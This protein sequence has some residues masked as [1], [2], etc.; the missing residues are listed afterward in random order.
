MISPSLQITANRFLSLAFRL[1]LLFALINHAVAAEPDCG[2]KLVDGTT[3][4]A[5]TSYIY[6]SQPLHPFYQ[7]EN[8]DGYCG[9]VSMMQAGLNN[10]QWMSQ[11]NARLICGTS[12]SQSGPNGACAAHHGN[13]NYNAQLLIEDPGTG[14]SGPNTY[15][16]AALCLANSRLHASTFN[17]SAQPSGIAGYEAY[18]S[19]VKQEVI[20]GHQVT[21]A[22]L[23]NGGTDPQYDHEV[24]VIKIGTNHSPTD[25]TYHPDD[26]IYFDDHGVYTLSG[27]HFT[28][29]PSIPPGAGSDSTGCTPYVFGYTFASLANTRAGANRNGAQAYSII[30][31]GDHTIH[32][33]TGGSGYDTVPILG[34]HNYGFS[35][36]GPE[37][38]TSETLPV[39]LTI[40][41]PTVTKGIPNPLDPLA[42]YDYENP[43]IGKSVWGQSCTNHPPSAWMTNFGLEATMSGLT[44][45]VRYNLYEYEFSSV[46]G[47]GSGAALPVPIRDFNA[48]AGLAT[49]VTSFI[50]T[51]STFSQTIT[52][53]SD[54]II[55]FRGVPASAP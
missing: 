45:G 2:Q 13:V 35:V 42:G 16:N 26:V 27:N 4:P 10:G 20:A 8:N 11:F 22:I 1:G 24:A 19:W 23:L 34:P 25:P 37:D 14:V 39:A 36:A 44:P 32:T 46:E 7:W 5:T 54:K 21:L 49:N 29:N 28:S 18:M 12:L 48:N 38:P 15:A 30:I 3:P 43:M 52:T 17:Y 51:A 9:E 55:V 53:T 33:S 6:P 47:E 40:I 31:P 50:A 41:G